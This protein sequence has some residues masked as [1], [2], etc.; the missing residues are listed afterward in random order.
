MNMQPDFLDPKSLASAVKAITGKN[1][2]PET[3]EGLDDL[4]A[5]ARSLVLQP[6]S[7]ETAA[8]WGHM[9]SPVRSQDRDLAVRPGGGPQMV[10]GVHIPDRLNL[11]QRGRTY[12]AANTHDGPSTSNR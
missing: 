1:C 2:D 6:D 8:I 10:E 4:R 11:L 12:V 7:P 5:I 3:P 9:K